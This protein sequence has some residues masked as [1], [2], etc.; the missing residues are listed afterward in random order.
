MGAR[1]GT[2]GGRSGILGG[3]SG[4]LVGEVVSWWEKWYLH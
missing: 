3:R 1:S 2:L 4:I